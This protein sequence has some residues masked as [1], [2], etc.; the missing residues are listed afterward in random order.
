MWGILGTPAAGR[1]PAF[2]T[3]SPVSTAVSPQTARPH[4]CLAW[5]LQGCCPAQGSHRPNPTLTS[6][7]GNLLMS[8]L[9]TPPEA[10]GGFL[11]QEKETFPLNSLWYD[12]SFGLPSAAPASV[13]KLYQIV[14]IVSKGPTTELL[15]L[16]PPTSHLQPCSPTDM[17]GEWVPLSQDVSGLLP[18]KGF[19]TPSPFGSMF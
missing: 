12:G 1:L 11:L 10:L 4:C 6:A 2:S 8:S 15:V 19:M 5:V 17:P 14:S 9:S 18:A 16:Y 3:S 7:L 13:G